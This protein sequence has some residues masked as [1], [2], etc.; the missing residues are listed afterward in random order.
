MSRRTL[1]L[2]YGLALLLAVCVIGAFVPVPLIA[3]G[4]GPS[5]DTLG[6]VNGKTVVTAGDRQNF[7]TTGHLN[8]TTVTVTDGLNA[9]NAV[10][11]WLSSRYQVIPRSVLYPPG[12]TEAQVTE[13]NNLLFSTSENDA[14]VAALR[15]LR[16][17]IEVRIK[18]VT[19]NA[20]A[21]SAL[22]DN[23]VLL[24]VNGEAVTSGARVKEIVAA[25]RPGE[26]VPIIYRRGTEPPIKATVTVGLRPGSKPDVPQGYF[27][28]V[29]PAVPVAPN[30]I[31]IALDDVGGPSAGLMFSLAIV[32]KL[33]P[34]DLT[35][36]RFI[37]G[38]GTID[39][40]GKV[41]EINGIPF[42]MMGAKEAGATVFLV[43][44]NN[45][46]EA[47]GTEPDGMQLIKVATLADAVNG[48]EA[49]KAGK[50]VPGC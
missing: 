40:R 6:Q 49:L 38:T 25:A 22:R 33:S 10:W 31:S 37:A 21:G 3:M 9:T 43:P 16:E 44:A 1:T 19:P 45:C 35:G 4:A 47:K 41:G 14:E 18:E 42:K 11:F 5:Y 39:D 20:P 23:D 29:A 50:P 8:M 48:L 32:D 17:P 46:A 12:A 15:Y 26:Q 28:V 36:G 34:I 2:V 7:P 27:G 30:Q 13:L 24:D